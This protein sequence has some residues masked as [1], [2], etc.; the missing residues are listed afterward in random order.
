MNLLTI[1]LRNT[2]RKP[3]RTALLLIVF[4]MGVM[5]VVA[6]AN[7]SRV[8]GESLEKKLTAYG[9][10]ILITPRIETL[11]VSYGGFSLGGMSM[12]QRFLSSSETINAIRSIGHKDRLAAVA[13]KLV[14]STKVN[15][16]TI[17]VVGVNW[18]EELSIKS[19][20][21]MDG[22]Y[23]T[24]DVDLIAGT[25]AAKKLGLAIGDKVIIGAQPFT[26][27]G[28]LQ[29]TGGDDDKVL[30][31]NL[32]YLQTVLN[33]PDRIHFVEVAAL[34]SGCPIQ[35][36]V[37]Q[38]SEALP[39]MRITALQN[40]VKQRM[41]SVN[42]V[43]RLALIVSL[44]ILLTACTMVGVSMLSAVNERKKEIGILRSLGYSKPRV[45]SIFCVEALII[46]I[47]AGVL[48]YASGFIISL[49]ILEALD[50]AG[51]ATLAFD[52]PR[53]A[54]ACVAM[55]GL[56]V[57]SALAPAWKASRIEPS[58]ALLSL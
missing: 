31:A 18:Q 20:W 12:G 15:G 19:Y 21:A 29:P 30:L 22:A 14:T 33:M 25:E 8:V 16:T 38:I 39:G 35:D 26:L 37:K 44:V 54:I 4:A 43:K 24:T 13:P 46:G 7:V 5:S 57:L 56:A 53:F 40:V 10:N 55:S 28:I 27:V 47:M 32:S 1:P 23:P 11:A 58:E 9:A 52:W 48:G 36:I 50:M 34:C 51:D 6:L 42:F 41:Y 2:R 49:R 17:G 3:L 45:F